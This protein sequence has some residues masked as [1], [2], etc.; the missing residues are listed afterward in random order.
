MFY[1]QWSFCYVL[2]PRSTGGGLGYSSNV[3]IKPISISLVRNLSSA[4]PVQSLFWT[5]T[6][7]AISS[8]CSRMLL[9]RFPVRWTELKLVACTSAI[10]ASLQQT[11]L[12]CSRRR[13]SSTFAP[14]GDFRWESK[15]QG[16][17]NSS[18]L[19]GQKLQIGPKAFR[20]GSKTKKWQIEAKPA[21]HLFWRENHLVQSKKQC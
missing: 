16:P 13:D 14:K 15:V 19:I 18:N 20:Q 9:F 1:S 5:P 12:V 17:M 4:V 2:P 6:H 21:W 3:I 7:A 10:S 11:R 8:C